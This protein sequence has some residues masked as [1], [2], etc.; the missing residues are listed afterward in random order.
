MMEEEDPRK[1]EGYSWELIPYTIDNEKSGEKRKSFW[2]DCVRERK[3][4]M[5]FPFCLLSVQMCVF[6]GVEKL[7]QSATEIECEKSE[8]EGKF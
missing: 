1:E 6:T 2:C 4:T 8:E 5:F 3:S 7:L